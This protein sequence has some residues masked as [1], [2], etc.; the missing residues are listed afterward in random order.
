MLSYN[1]SCLQLK[2]MRLKNLAE[3]LKDQ[4]A[5]NDK[6]KDKGVMSEQSN[7]LKKNDDMSKHSQEMIDEM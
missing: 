1:D 4:R 7:T 5:K 3:D 6:A 2:A